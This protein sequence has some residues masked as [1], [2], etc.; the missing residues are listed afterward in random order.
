M[1]VTKRKQIISSLN[2]AVP[3]IGLSELPDQIDGRY[4][5]HIEGLEESL[6]PYLKSKLI[7]GTQLTYDVVEFMKEYY[8]STYEDD[9]DEEL[10]IPEELKDFT[11][12]DLIKDP[13]SE[14]IILTLDDG[15]IFDLIINPISSYCGKIRFNME[16]FSYNSTDYLGPS[17]EG[18]GPGGIGKYFIGYDFDLKLDSERK[19]PVV[20]Y[21]KGKSG[22][23][24]K[25]VE[26]MSFTTK[27]PRDD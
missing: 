25:I 11:L 4:A 3:P 19:S 12:Q 23:V 9:S 6:P 26:I 24:I 27:L 5:K 16:P 2:R 20:L 1:S 10:E 18:V 15:E 8:K 21:K 17:F 7:Y 22:D 13:L 14:S